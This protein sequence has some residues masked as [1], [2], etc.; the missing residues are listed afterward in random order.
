MGFRA[1]CKF[2]DCLVRP[3]EG[4]LPSSALQTIYLP[5]SAQPVR[6]LAYCS[7]AHVLFVK[8]SLLYS[9]VCVIVIIM[10]DLLK[11]GLYKYTIAILL[12]S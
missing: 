5:R 8:Y 6:K 2:T 7:Q 9:R 12:I 3:A 4:I 10:C 1:I 11:G